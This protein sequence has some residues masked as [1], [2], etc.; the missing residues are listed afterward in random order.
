MSCKGS[1]SPLVLDYEPKEKKDCGCGCNGDKNYKT[2]NVNISNK[3]GNLM[4]NGVI[5]PHN[6]SPPISKP[7]LNTNSQYIYIAIGLILLYSMKS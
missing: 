7:Q 5:L 1:I 4:R 6:E 3:S 2:G